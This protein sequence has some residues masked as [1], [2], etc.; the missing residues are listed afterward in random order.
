MQIKMLLTAIAFLWLASGVAAQ[1]KRSSKG[2]S[3]KMS[4]RNFQ[5]LI[6]DNMPNSIGYSQ[7]ATVTGGT[8]V[9][10]AGQVAF[11]KS[12]NVVGHDDFRAQVQQVFENLTSSARS[13]A[14]TSL[15]ELLFDC[16]GQGRV[17][18]S[19]MS[20]RCGFDQDDATLFFSNRIMH[21]VFSD[22]RNRRGPAPLPYLRTAAA[23]AYTPPGTSRPL[24]RV[25]ATQV[26]LSPL[27]LS[28]TPR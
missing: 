24:A 2:A 13:D 6:P 4:S 21:G 1:E 9:F 3:K 22:R 11:D 23:A 5:L 18:I 28:R 8:V 17:Y 10:V 26:A 16:L 12:G 20:G 27:R 15:T 14:P 19:G 25:C 7:V